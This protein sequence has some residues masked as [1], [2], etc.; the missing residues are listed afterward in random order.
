MFSFWSLGCKTSYD[1]SFRRPAPD[2]LWLSISFLRLLK[3]LLSLDCCFLSIYTSSAMIWEVADLTL[4]IGENCWLSINDK[5]CP[6]CML[7]TGD[8]FSAGIFRP[9]CY[10]D[11][12][13]SPNDVLYSNEFDA[14]LISAISQ[15]LRG[16]IFSKF[17]FGM[18]GASL[19]ACSSWKN[20]GTIGLGYSLTAS[21]CLWTDVIWLLNV[22]ENWCSSV[23]Y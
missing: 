13:S 5:N 1:L 16:W 21:D 11:L 4:S 6:R 7:T 17:N 14:C 9:S 18:I 20:W 23:L 15:K 2:F 12:E 3:F 19:S 22:A 8:L 10:Y